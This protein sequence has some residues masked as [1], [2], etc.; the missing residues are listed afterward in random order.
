VS[1]NFKSKMTGGF[2]WR[3]TV[4]NPSAY[5][6]SLHERTKHERV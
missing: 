3:Q 6:D 2:H 4:D 1:A 5:P